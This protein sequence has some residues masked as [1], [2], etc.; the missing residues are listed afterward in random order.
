M[1]C[2]SFGIMINPLSYTTWSLPMALVN[3]LNSSNTFGRETETVS[4]K[5]DN[6]NAGLVLSATL[7]GEFSLLLV[8]ILASLTLFD[9]SHEN[10]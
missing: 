2:C 8:P 6:N 1:D 9:L 7:F 3:S 5:A 10:F 4:Y